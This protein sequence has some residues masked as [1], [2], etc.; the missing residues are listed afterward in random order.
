MSQTA[1]ASGKTFFGHPRGLSTL[2]FTEMWERFSYYGMRALL[3]LFMVSS[4]ENGGFGYEDSKANAI[5]GLYT[6]G[7]YL[8]ALFGG[9]LADRYIG[10]RKAVWYGGII[11][12]AGHFSM[13]LPSRMSFFFGLI[14]IVVGTGLLKPNVSTIVGELY[15][16]GGSRRDAG[17]SIFYTGI[18]LGAF[19]GPLICGYLGENVDWH[20]GFAA[21]GV[22]MVFG[23]IQYKLTEGYL[24]NCGLPPQRVAGE[25]SNSKLGLAFGFVALFIIL[26][27]GL[28]FADVINLAT[29]QGIAKAFGLGIALIALFYFSYQFAAGGHNSEDKKRLVGIII[30]FLAS[31]TFWSGFEQAGSSLNL[32]AKYFTQRDMLGFTVPASWFQ[33]INPIFIIILAPFFGALWIQLGKKNM[34]PSIPLKFAFGLIFLGLGFL[35]MVGAAKLAIDSKVGAQWLILTY[36]LHTTGELCLS[37]VGL[38]TITKLAP[39][40]IVGQMMGIWFLAT[41]LGNLIAGLA[42]G[43]FDFS[44]FEQADGA[45]GVVEG[46]IAKGETTLNAET[47]AS[48]EKAGGDVVSQLDGSLVSVGSNLESVRTALSSVIDKVKVGAAEQM[49]NL[50]MEIMLITAGV[51]LFLLLFSKPFKGLM[52]PR[53]ED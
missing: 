41:S 25:S 35:V 13:A 22:F 37:P 23:L 43:R 33:S 38:S 46:A 39:K 44:P 19:A 45:M 11:I 51:G 32:F 24:G 3:V 9:W 21:A 29:I 8:L 15:P 47:L 52:K 49:P 40:R 10:Q 16:E 1:A 48:L 2:F 31:A 28:H 12:A 20:M 5:Y 36:L 50:F 4:V 42:A 30:L 18:N 26:F 27:A 17:F 53:Q 7:V 6:G 14:L 34:D